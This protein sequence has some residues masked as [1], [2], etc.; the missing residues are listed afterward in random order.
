MSQQ[1]GVNRRRFLIGIG[2]A[3]LGLATC[4]GAGVLA[5]REPHIA[6]S[7]LSC[8]QG[9]SDQGKVLVTYASQ[10]GSTGEVAAAIAQTLCGSGMA[11]D[12]KQ[13][14]RVDDLSSYRAVIVGAPVHSSEWMTEAVDFVSANQ[15]LLSQLPVAYFLTCM[16]LAVTDRPAELQKIDNVL[17]KVQRDIPAVIP[18][19]KGLFAGALDYGKMSFMYRMMYNMVSPDNTTG[20][21][22]DWT[23]ICAWANIIG[24]KLLERGA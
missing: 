13:V 8:G 20:D 9:V 6:F 16:T 11:A 5:V 7:E 10:F 17:E 24:S 2:A 21:F 19:G 23:A 14:T 12:V 15:E 4:G 22:R 18:V 1:K 3:G